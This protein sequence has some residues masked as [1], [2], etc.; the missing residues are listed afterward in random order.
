MILVTG[1][2]V[3]R[4]LDVIILHFHMSNDEYDL[5]TDNHVNWFVF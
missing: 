3:V 2:N 5:V 4:A 1:N